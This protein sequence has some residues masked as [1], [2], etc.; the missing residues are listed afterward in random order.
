MAG[1]ILDE[2]NKNPFSCA[3]LSSVEAKRVK[4]SEIT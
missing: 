1:L 3:T 2:K 4:L